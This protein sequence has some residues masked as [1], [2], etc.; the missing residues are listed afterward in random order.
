LSGPRQVRGIE[1]ADL[2][3]LSSAAGRDALRAARRGDLRAEDGSGTSIPP[4]VWWTLGTAALLGLGG[5]REARS[6]PAGRAA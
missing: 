6:R 3:G 1:L 5:W 4:A 2:S